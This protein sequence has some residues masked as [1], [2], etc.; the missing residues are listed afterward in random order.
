V[1]HNHGHVRCRNCPLGRFIACNAAANS[2][3][4]RPDLYVDKTRVGYLFRNLFLI[5]K[6]PVMFETILDRLA[7]SRLQLA[8]AAFVTA[9]IVRYGHVFTSN[10]DPMPKEYAWMGGAVAF[11]S[12]A[13]LVIW[14]VAWVGSKI[15]D[16]V[17]RYV[18][19]LRMRRLRTI[20]P[21]DFLMLEFS[22]RPTGTYIPSKTKFY[23]SPYTRLELTLALKELEDE[24]LIEQV[25][26]DVPEYRLTDLGLKQAATI[27]DELRQQ[28]KLY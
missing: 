27:E 26:G 9:L 11:G 24:G 4:S 1:S 18:V 5:A 21:R 8:L 14:F 17:E 3:P 7:P 16:A 12:G 6:V 10:I 28:G 13:L 15:V 19:T 2:Q 25:H 22:Y 20:S 23:M